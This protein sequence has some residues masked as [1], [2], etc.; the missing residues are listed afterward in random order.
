MAW[1]GWPYAGVSS[2]TLHLTVTPSIST[3]PIPRLFKQE[4]AF[5][6]GGRL[7][8]EYLTRIS[9]GIIPQTQI[10]RGLLDSSVGKESTCNAGDPVRFFG[11]VDPLENGKCHPLQYSGLENSLD[12]LV[13]GAAKSQTGLSNFPFH[14]GFPCGSTGKESACNVG[15]LGSIPGLGR[16]LEEGKGYPLQYSG[17]ENS[18]NYIVHGITKSQTRLSH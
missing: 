5:W 18:M 6:L 3:T 8:Q 13:H 11:W 12:C 4:T 17:L 14:L 9:S 7:R 10:F 2:V 1:K 16:F 15:D